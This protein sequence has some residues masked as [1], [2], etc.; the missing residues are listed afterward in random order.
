MRLLDVF[1]NYSGQK[2]LSERAVFEAAMKEKI[3]SEP[4]R[5]ADLLWEVYQCQREIEF[6]QA[7]LAELGKEVSEYLLHD[8]E[9]APARTP[10]PKKKKKG[11]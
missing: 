9:R 2:G 7:C 1:N 3:G 11:G 5:M 8:W 6:L 10:K 4:Y